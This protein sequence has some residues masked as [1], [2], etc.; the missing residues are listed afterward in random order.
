MGGKGKWVSK[1]ARGETGGTLH[2]YFKNALAYYWQVFVKPY[3]K[4]PGPIE[5]DETLVSKKFSIYY[6]FP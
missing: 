6:D 1:L 3:L 5:I 4:L 2:K